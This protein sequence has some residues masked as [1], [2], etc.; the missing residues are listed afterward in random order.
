M[1]DKSKATRALFI[2]FV[3]PPR[4]VPTGESRP[5]REA[6]KVLPQSDVPNLYLDMCDREAVNET[7]RAAGAIPAAG[8]SAHMRQIPLPWGKNGE[9]ARISGRGIAEGIT[10]QAGWGAGFQAGLREEP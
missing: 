8:S 9:S 7:W 10:L 2:I 5:G 3:E 4:E 6:R 1:A